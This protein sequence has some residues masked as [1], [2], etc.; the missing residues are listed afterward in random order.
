MLS[1]FKYRLYLKPEQETRLNRSLLS[2]CDLYND[3]KAEEMR[4][5]QGR[6]QVDIADHVQGPRPGK[7]RPQVCRPKIDS[8]DPYSIY[9][10]VPFVNGTIVKPRKN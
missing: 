3:L 10:F 1:A 5:V 8:A 9:Y 4:K 7:R 6:A 2:L